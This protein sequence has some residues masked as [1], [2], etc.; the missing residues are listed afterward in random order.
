MC[1]MTCLGQSVTLIL[2]DLTS[3]LLRDLSGQKVYD[4]I[5][6]DEKNTMAPKSSV[7]IL[8]SKEV[9]DDKLSPLET[10]HTYFF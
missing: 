1:N 4:S 6:L 8:N 9:I 7:Q 3:K 10:V 5:C 2:D